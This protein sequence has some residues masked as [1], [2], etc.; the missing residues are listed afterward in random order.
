MFGGVQ[1]ALGNFDKGDAAPDSLHVPAGEYETEV[2]DAKLK[3]TGRTNADG[4]RIVE[5]AITHTVRAGEFAGRR[6]WHNVILTK[7]ARSHAIRDLGWYGVESFGQL[8]KPFPPGVFCRI[9]VIVV[10]S[11]TGAEFNKVKGVTVTRIDPPKP[12]PDAPADVDPPSEP[13]SPVVQP[14]PTPAKGKGKPVAGTA[15][16]P[17]GKKS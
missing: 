2:T 13:P 12:D 4:E 8:G 3:D 9:P 5:Y 7:K 14:N 1:A 15:K 17:R 11:D 10:K 16:K 6:I